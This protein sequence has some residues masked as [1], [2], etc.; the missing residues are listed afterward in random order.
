[1]KRSRWKMIGNTRPET[2]EEVLQLLLENRGVGPAFLNGSLK[3]L[4]PFLAIEGLTQGAELTAYH[5]SQGHKIVL[6]GDYDCDGITSAAQL[7]L[8]LRD[9]GYSNYRAVIP[10]RSEGYGVPQRAILENPDAGLLV[11]LDC[12]TQDVQAVTLARS[13]GMDCIVIDHHEPPEQGFAPANVLINPK[14]P[15]CPSS[16]KEFCSA[17][18]TLLFLAALRRKLRGIFPQ[19][20]LGP[21]YLALAAIGTVADIVPLID[22]N[23]ILTKAGLLHLGNEA[24]LPLKE[25]IAMSGLSGKRLTTG[26]IG[27]YLGPRLNVAGRMASAHLAFDLLTGEDPGVIHRIAQELNRLN[28]RRQREEEEAFEEIRRRCSDISST[29]RTFVMG[30]PKWPNGII[31]IIASR[32]Q[33]ELHYGPTVIFSI[34]KRLGIARGSARSIPGFNIHAALKQCEQHLLK[35][36]GHK[37]AAGLTISTEE[38]EA[39]AASF[40]QIAGEHPQEVFTPQAKVDMELDLALVSIE[41]LESLKALEPHGPGNPT[42][43]FAAK[44]VRTRVQKSFG[45]NQNHLQLVLEDSIAGV[46]WRGHASHCWEAGDCMDVVF[47]LEWDNFLRKPILNIKSTGNLF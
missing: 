34:D 40:E 11:A 6:V 23:R 20:G 2:V 46:F 7:S 41:L 42:P 9:I 27:Y 19:P 8:F 47:Q 32:I 16:F 5:L 3:D 26:H 25:M 43:T 44:R 14:Q 45:K 18:L 12:G 1:M 4:E 31:G 21:K 38:I 13:H 28:S 24:F 29:N 30:D 33:Q 35:W 37:M 10:D 17:G 36:G 22:A 39:F 15:G